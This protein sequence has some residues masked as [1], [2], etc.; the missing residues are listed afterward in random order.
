MKSNLLRKYI[1]PGAALGLVSGFAL[2]CTAGPGIIITPPAPPT[3]IISA[4]TPP[5]VPVVVAP[6]PAPVMVVPDNYYYDGTEYV[7]VVGGQYYYLGPGNSWVVMDNDRLHRF[8]DWQRGHS[9]WQSHPI[10]NDKYRGVPAHVQPM[11]EDHPVMHDDHGQY[12]HDHHGPP[13]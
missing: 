10:H 12:D 2:T 8:H 9:D 1:L 7:G 4:P 6:A 11:H 3:V 5:P 13:Q